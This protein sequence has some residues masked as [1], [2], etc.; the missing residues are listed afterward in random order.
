MIFPPILYIFAT[1]NGHTQYYY[2]MLR[3]II[4]FIALL[5]GITVSAVGKSIMLPQEVDN[6]TFYGVDFSQV[7]IVGDDAPD[8]Q[9]LQAFRRINDLFVTE[10]EKYDIARYLRTHIARYDFE[11]VAAVNAATDLS[12]ARPMQATLLDKESLAAH[13][14]RLPVTG[15]GVGLIIIADCLD[16]T[17]E[18]GYFHIL[19]FDRAT[20]SVI[21]Q[22][23][24]S[25]KARG[26]GLRNHWARAMLNSIRSL[27]VVRP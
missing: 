23:S 4:L 6:V 10:P 15:D 25:G 16:K 18:T 1:Y 7:N 9:Y 2:T 26:F 3:N 19:F 11:M 21:A 27:R 22:A 5:S 14:S 13:I 8:S 24:L 12:R 17:R 20:R